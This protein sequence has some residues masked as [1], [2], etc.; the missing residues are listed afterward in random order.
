[1]SKIYYKVI[2]NDDV[3]P[4]SVYYMED[5]SNL[6]VY[7]M[8]SEVFVSYCGYT[9]LKEYFKWTRPEIYSMKKYEWDEFKKVLL[10][11][12]LGK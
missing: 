1:M 3:T 2:Y 6:Y 9:S 4:Y 5:G 12:K 7:D 10:V 11:S 8:V